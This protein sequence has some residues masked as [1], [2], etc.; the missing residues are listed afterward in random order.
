MKAAARLN[1]EGN[2]ADDHDNGQK[3]LISKL[4]PHSQSSLVIK[5]TKTFMNSKIFKSNDLRE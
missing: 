3:V 2:D 4:F 5:P 1:T